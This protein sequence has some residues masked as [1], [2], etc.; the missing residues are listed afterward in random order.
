MVGVWYFVLELK[1]VLTAPSSIKQ[2][3]PKDTLQHF[4]CAQKIILKFDDYDSSSFSVPF[5]AVWPTRG[6]FLLGIEKQHLKI[7]YID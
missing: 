4:L 3:R 7:E 1:N 6:G 2:L 5:N